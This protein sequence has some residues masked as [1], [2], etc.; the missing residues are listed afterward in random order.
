M[1]TF[2]RTLLILFLFLAFSC[3]KEKR[4]NEI[5]LA[6]IE[7]IEQENTRLTLSII[8]HWQE[9]GQ[10]GSDK[11]LVNMAKAVRTTSHSL[12]TLNP[13]D[14]R[15]FTN[16]W[17]E[18]EDILDSIGNLL[19]FKPENPLN[20]ND[21][22]ESIDLM[23]EFALSEHALLE[24]IAIRMGAYCGWDYGNVQFK[25]NQYEVGEQALVTF[26]LTESFP[27]QIVTFDSVSFTIDGD[28]A[29]V[30]YEMEIF[31]KTCVVTFTPRIEGRYLLTLHAADVTD[32]QE[33]FE[34][35]ISGYCEVVD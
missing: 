3:N 13:S 28:P 9:L 21:S 19:A 31:V 24:H 4:T 33:G 14:S 16:A 29:S 5:D 30:D 32:R 34:M 35:K 23:K 26:G 10:P 18:A 2:S 12:T 1:T 7:F 25:K 27:D 22:R 8:S 17:L 6:I 20:F 11:Q 15:S